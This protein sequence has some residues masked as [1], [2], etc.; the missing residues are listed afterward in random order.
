M[1]HTDDEAAQTGMNQSRRIHPQGSPQKTPS[2]ACAVTA[3]GSII[4]PTI[5]SRR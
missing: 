3:A 5:P 2:F 1:D 4:D